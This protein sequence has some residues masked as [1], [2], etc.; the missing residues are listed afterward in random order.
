MVLDAAADEAWSCDEE[1]EMEEEEDAVVLELEACFVVSAT[2]VEVAWLV[3]VATELLLT[4]VVEAATFVGVPSEGV[5]EQVAVSP[6][7]KDRRPSVSRASAD[8]AGK[9]P[10]YALKL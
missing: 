5:A 3:T 2:A 1:E 10:T 9:V 4:A 7:V 6:T 8:P